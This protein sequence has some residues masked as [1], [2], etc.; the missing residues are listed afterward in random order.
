[1][2]EPVTRRVERLVALK[3]SQA[4]EMKNV[5]SLCNTSQ[6]DGPREDGGGLSY[7][8]RKNEVGMLKTIASRSLP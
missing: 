4:M 5:K 8:Q 7:A 6:D 2:V 1:M 3:H